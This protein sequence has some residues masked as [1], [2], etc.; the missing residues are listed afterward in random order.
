MINPQSC[1]CVHFG[2]PFASHLLDLMMVRVLIGRKDARRN[3]REVSLARLGNRR[4]K[5]GPGHG[6][7]T[8]RGA[9]PTGQPEHTRKPFCRERAADGENTKA[10]NLLALP[11]QPPLSKLHRG[12]P[13]GPVSRD[14]G[15]L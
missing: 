14:L 8:D 13:S 11:L 1:G 5:R 4:T 10:C 9:R 15:P 6:S 3:S 12:R 7:T 2:H